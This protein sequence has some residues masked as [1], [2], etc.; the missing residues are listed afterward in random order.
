M[1]VLFGVLIALLVTLVFAGGW[2]LT[3]GRFYVVSSPSMSPDVP[4]GSLV[5]T[6]P[7]DVTS[8]HAPTLHVGQ[9]IAFH[10]PDEA[11][12]YTHRIVEVQPG[13]TYKTRGDLETIDDPWVLHPGDVSG[14]AVGT[15]REVGW[16]VRALP[17]LFVSGILVLALAS[18]RR[19]AWSLSASILGACA[20]VAVPS[21][22]L[23]PYVRG[24]L[25]ESG[26]KAGLQTAHVVNTGLLPV[27]FAM[28]DGGSSVALGGWPATVTGTT[29]KTGP[30]DIIGTAW[31]PWWGWA[32]VVLFCATP[33]VAAL[34]G[35]S[36][37]RNEV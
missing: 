9:I 21:L 19:H 34:V 7:V 3:G 12:L 23:R 6:R 28:Q 16:L 24:M 32:I 20:V 4:V 30:M 11:S 27:K 1:Y 37:A 33:L 5:L 36:Y 35:A 2:F 13:P 26:D 10:P 15:Y 31:L 14:V 25:L 17:F 22:I 8:G 29:P 18:L